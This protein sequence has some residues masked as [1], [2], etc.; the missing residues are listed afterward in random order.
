MLFW[1][2]VQTS[3]A[4]YQEV[5][6]VLCDSAGAAQRWR[7]KAPI[8]LLVPSLFWAV[9]ESQAQTRAIE[10]GRQRESKQRQQ[11]AFNAP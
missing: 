4:E 9:S 1:A 8:A 6:S 11:R 7:K 3:P 2:L 10:A 5:E